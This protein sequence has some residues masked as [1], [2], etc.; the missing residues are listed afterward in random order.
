MLPII[1]ASSSIYRRQL[2]EKIGI[3]CSYDAPNIDE[4]AKPAEPATQLAL[5]L[6]KQK[7]QA[8]W[9]QH[10]DH[11]I[12]GSDQVAE[13]NGQILGKPGN[14]PN[15]VA[16]LKACSGHIVHFHTA[17]AV[18]NTRSGRLQSSLSHY[19]VRF[20]TLSD[21]QIENYLQIEQPY[22]CA[23]SFKSEGLGICLF[24]YIRGDD[25]NSLIGLPL[26][27]LT[28]MLNEEGINPLD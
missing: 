14:H 3:S 6:A 10:P 13:L 7:A 25:P 16:Q 18:L 5:R 8:L 23:G 20:R 11:L 21:T 28:N 15:A 27:E 17:L 22:D 24:D 4:T 9:S 1:L 12:I 26:I 19:E 2:I